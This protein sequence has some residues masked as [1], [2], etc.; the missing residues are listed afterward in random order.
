MDRL[1]AK[2]WLRMGQYWACADCGPAI[3]GSCVKPSAGPL[4]SFAP[5][6][7][8]RQHFVGAV[9]AHDLEGKLVDRRLGRI[10]S[11]AGSVFQ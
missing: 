8:A 6:N 2:R 9:A 1:V 11:N 5:F 4:F 7:H 3:Q 10:R